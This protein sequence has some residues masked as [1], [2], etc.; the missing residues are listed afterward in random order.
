MADFQKWSSKLES[1]QTQ[2]F[3][4]SV[5]PLENAKETKEK[6]GITF[7]VAYGLDAVEIS[8][9][10]GAFYEKSK[11][12]LHATGFLVRQN[13]TIDVACY[14]TGTLGRLTPRD[15][16]ALVRFYKKQQEERL[17]ML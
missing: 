7:P 13:N 11:G 9:V 2:I 6:N 8:R 16:F 10:T 1:E 15:V 3:A 4:G 17:K 14:S 5:D 12:F